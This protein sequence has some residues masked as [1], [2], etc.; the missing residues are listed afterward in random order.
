M[1]KGISHTW[2]R[3][4]NVCLLSVVLMLLVACQATEAMPTAAQISIIEGN[5]AVPSQTATPFDTPVPSATNTPTST[6]D[7]VPTETA[8]AT[9]VASHNPIPTAAVAATPTPSAT[10][11]NLPMSTNTPHPAATATLDVP[12]LEI[13]RLAENIGQEVTVNGS[14]VNTASFSGGFRFTLSDGTGQVTLLLWHNVYDDCWDAPQLNRGATVRAT[15]EV[16]LFEGDLEIVPDFGGDVKVTAV[17]GLFAPDHDIGELGNYMGEL[18]QIT[19]QINRL[20]STSSGP[21]IFVAD[22]T[23]EIVVFIWNDILDRVPN[24]VALGVP[25]TRVRVVGFVQE[26]HSNREIVPALPYDIEVL[27]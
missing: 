14:V 10:A 12:T 20:E 22:E 17:S 9:A 1:I 2:Q 11:T 27:P 23:G 7:L 5:T 15:G 13:G 21:K 26:Y 24:N 25:G 6:Q 18:V 19:G 3:W 16:S 4:F 8:T